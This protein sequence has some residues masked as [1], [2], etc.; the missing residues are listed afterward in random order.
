VD[1]DAI[2]G[3]RGEGPVVRDKETG[4]VTTLMRLAPGAVLPDHEHV[5]IEQTY[6]L[7]G[8][9]V[10]KEGSAAGLTVGPGEF[11]WR[12]AGSRHVAWTAEGALMLAM[13]QV[14]NKFFE[15]DGRVTAISG[16]DWNSLWGHVFSD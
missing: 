7:E 5:K 8:K 13:F 10:D 9:L 4:L 1:E 12:E 3:L 16:G 2:P 15:K 6:I 11:V 14:P